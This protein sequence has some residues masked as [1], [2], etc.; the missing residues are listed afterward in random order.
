MLVNRDKTFWGKINV[1]IF[2]KKKH[3]VQQQMK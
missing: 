3:S 1:N 2:E